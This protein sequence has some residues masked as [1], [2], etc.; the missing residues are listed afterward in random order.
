MLIAVTSTNGVD[1]DQHFGHAESLRVYSYNNCSPKLVRDVAVEKYS[2]DDPK[3][4][5]DLARFAAIANQILDCKVLLTK[6]IGEKPQQELEKLGIK[7]IVL[8]GLIT[9]ALKLAHDSI[10]IGDCQEPQTMGNCSCS[11]H[12]ET[13]PITL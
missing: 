13:K 5:F 4:Q 8:S 10:C 11:H 3:H 6:K 9:D 1:I 12:K 2:V 7:T